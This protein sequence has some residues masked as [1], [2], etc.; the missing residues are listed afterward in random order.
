MFSLTIVATFYDC[1]NRRDQKDVADSDMIP[2]IRQTDR[3]R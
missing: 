2:M 3:R 1:N